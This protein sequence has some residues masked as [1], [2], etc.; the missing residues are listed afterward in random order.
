ME[1]PTPY[2]DNQGLL[3]N[4]TNFLEPI[5]QVGPILPSALIDVVDSVEES[6]QKV[7]IELNNFDV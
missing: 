3:N 6:E 4:Q 7:F 2:D 5:W 1:I